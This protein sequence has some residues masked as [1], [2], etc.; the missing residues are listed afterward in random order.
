[1]S[2]KTEE[3]PQENRSESAQQQLTQDEAYFPVT[4]QPQDETRTETQ[5]SIEVQER[6]VEVEGRF[7]E[8]LKAIGEETSQLAQFLVQER[9]LTREL[10]SFLT[11]ILKNLKI[12]FAIP[13]EYLVA[14]GEEAKQVRLGRDGYLQ[15]TRN[16]GKVDSRPLEEHSPE[17][18]LKVL[19]VISP[20]L[21]RM[22]KACRRN[23]SRRIGLLEK[24][25]H[26]LK[27][28]QE[29]FALL[30]KEGRK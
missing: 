11:Q 22:I 10:C 1:M 14:L 4:S 20:E 28:M 9:K 29:A 26:E 5:A 6:S 7:Q 27:T 30:D 13:S 19:L 25:R 23:V 17:I 15:I 3:K 24:I 21:E 8:F 12:S 2:E 16:D 18:I